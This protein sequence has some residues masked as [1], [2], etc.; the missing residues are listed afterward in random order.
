[1][2]VGVG[3]DAVEIARIGALLE[4]SEERFERRVFTAAESE[5]CRGCL[6]YTSDAADE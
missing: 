2:I 5:Y 4:R 1:M 3:V 6:L